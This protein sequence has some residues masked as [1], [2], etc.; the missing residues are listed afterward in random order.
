MALPL[1][2]RRLGVLY[3]DVL[4][5]WFPQPAVPAVVVKQWPPIGHGASEV[6]RHAND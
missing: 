4:V 3:Q 5:V 6:D 2:Q 1:A